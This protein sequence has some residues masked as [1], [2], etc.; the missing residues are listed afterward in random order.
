M[1]NADLRQ[2]LVLMNQ[3]S[4][5]PAIPQITKRLASDFCQR[6]KAVAEFYEFDRVDETSH[7]I[8]GNRW[9]RYLVPDKSQR[10]NVIEEADL[11][12]GFLLLTTFAHHGGGELTDLV[13][14][15][16]HQG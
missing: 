3:R 7:A 12:R 15:F 5:A 10:I 9:L 16:S 11:L 13:E 8:I 1:L 4:E 2:R 6:H 14:R